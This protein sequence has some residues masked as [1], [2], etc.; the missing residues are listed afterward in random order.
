[1]SENHT[2]CLALQREGLGG[3]SGGGPTRSALPG[4]Q[5][6]HICK[7]SVPPD[8]WPVGTVFTLKAVDVIHH[9]IPV[10]FHLCEP[11][12]SLCVCLN[13][14]DLGFLHFHLAQGG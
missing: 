4:L 13:Q 10:G 5:Q 8:E 6:G 2:E 7:D 14:A 3:Q 12:H 11:N 9:F 1:M